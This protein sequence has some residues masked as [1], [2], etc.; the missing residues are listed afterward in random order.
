MLIHM[1]KYVY[2]FNWLEAARYYAQVHCRGSY[3]FYIII[4]VET[5]EVVE[6]WCY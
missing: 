5:D 2:R 3:E 1:D 6:K 4:D